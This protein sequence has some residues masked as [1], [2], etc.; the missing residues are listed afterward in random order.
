MRK[1]GNTMATCNERAMHPWIGHK[2]R[3]GHGYPYPGTTMPANSK[4]AAMACLRW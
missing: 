3:L 4:A 1:T 2:G